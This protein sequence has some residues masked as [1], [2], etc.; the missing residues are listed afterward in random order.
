MRIK[1][2]G[3]LK[4]CLGCGMSI[5]KSRPSLSIYVT[6]LCN[7][8]QH[9]FYYCCC[10]CCCM[11]VGVSDGVVGLRATTVV[12]VWGGAGG[13]GKVAPLRWHWPFPL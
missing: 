4:F 12:D 13:E 11:G 10:C 6:V 7:S 2:E 3:V 1:R 9:P 5:N 8:Q